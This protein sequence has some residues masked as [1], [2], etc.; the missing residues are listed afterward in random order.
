M[1]PPQALKKE[2]NKKEITVV[3]FRRINLHNF[4]GDFVG[5]MSTN[6]QKDAFYG[7]L[8]YQIS[9]SLLCFL[10]KYEDKIN[11]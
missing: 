5:A 2:L 1:I 6:N 10:V 9:N 11:F 4:Q 7:V 8:Q 3:I